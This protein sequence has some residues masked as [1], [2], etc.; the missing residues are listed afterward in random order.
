MSRRPSC[1]RCRSSGSGAHEPVEVRLY[2]T[3]RPVTGGGRVDLAGSHATIGAVLEGLIERF[4]D[5]RALLFASEGGVRPLVAI[6]V[7]GRDIRHLDGLGTA[8]GAES[9][10]DI[11]P[12]VAGG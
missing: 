8:V 5:L 9:A 4:P 11:F 3:L 2:A 6:M 12:P 10:V 1:G 7:D